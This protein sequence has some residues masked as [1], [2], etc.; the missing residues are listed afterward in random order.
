M[1]LVRGEGQSLPA[2]NGWPVSLNLWDWAAPSC[3][4]SQTPEPQAQASSP[5]QWM[6]LNEGLVKDLGQLYYLTINPKKPPDLRNKH[7]RFPME[8]LLCTAFRYSQ[9]LEIFFMKA[10]STQDK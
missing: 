1:G 9:E 7:L 8:T 4:S 3:G 10:P 2:S 6:V 5:R